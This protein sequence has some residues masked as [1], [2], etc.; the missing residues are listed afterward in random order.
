[1]SYYKAMYEKLFPYSPYLN[2]RIGLEILIEIGQD[3]IEALIDARSKVHE[4]RDKHCQVELA[5][6]FQHSYEQIPDQQVEKTPSDFIIENINACQTI[7]ELESFKILASATK[8]LQA[9]YSKKHL[10]L[11]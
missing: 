2:E 3:P 7:E 1:M 4:F 11:L 6:Q 5:H 8:E 9:A 10:Q